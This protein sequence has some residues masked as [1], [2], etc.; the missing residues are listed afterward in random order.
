M[1]FSL[2]N[3]FTCT[4]RTCLRCWM[5]SISKPIEECVSP[6]VVVVVKVALNDLRWHPHQVIV[7]AL[8]V[9]RSGSSCERCS[10]SLISVADTLKW[11]W[12]VSI[13]RIGFKQFQRINDK[14][15][16]WFVRIVNVHIFSRLSLPFTKRN[17][18]RYEV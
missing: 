11:V 12:L 16:S 5:D 14:L 6:G 4:S 8:F 18:R 1:G 2:F 15:L 10:P 17:V 9:P 3:V 7:V 13:L